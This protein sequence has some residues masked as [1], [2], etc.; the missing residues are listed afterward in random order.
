MTDKNGSSYEFGAFIL[1]TKQNLLLHGSE[2]VKLPAKAY[3]LLYFFVRNPNQ[4]I[5]KE[6]LM[7]EVWKDSFV[8]EANLAV[9]ISNLRKVLNGDVNG[10][11]AIETFPKV[12]YRF[13]AEI[14]LLEDS[15][16]IDDLIGRDRKWTG[17]YKNE[18]I[19]PLTSK[20]IGQNSFL[21][22]NRGK[23]SAL[24]IA[25][26]ITVLF[27]AGYVYFVSGDA[28]AFRNLKVVR[29]TNLGMA[30]RPAVSPDG[31]YV[32][33]A[34]DEK[35]GFSIWLK[36]IGSASET[37]IVPHADGVLNGISF[38][39]DGKSLTYGARLKGQEPGVWVIPMLGG[40]SN[41]LPLA[42]NRV[43][44]SPDGSRIVFLRNEL[45]EGK[46]HVVVA[47]ADGTDQRVVTTRQAPDYYWTA[48]E[49]SWSPDGKRVVCTAQNA[50]ESTPRLVEVDL[51]AGTESVITKQTWTTMRGV[52]W[53]PDGNG[54]LV[55]GAEETTSIRQLWYVSYPQGVATRISN[56]TINYSEISVS[57]DGHNIAT[58]ERKTPSSIWVAPVEPRGLD[59]SFPLVDTEKE[60]RISSSRADG[61]D[62]TEN[63]GGLTWTPDGK[64]VFTSEE[65]G[66]VDIWT[67]SADGSGRKQLITD[68]RWDTG[69]DVSPDG[70]T[71]AFMSRRL[72]TE[73]IWL[74][75]SDGGNQRRI[76][77]RLIERTPAFSPDGK[78]LYFTGWGTG[79]ANIWRLH[80]EGGESE[81]VVDEISTRPSI[82]D[83][84]QLLLYG[85]RPGFA[86]RSVESGSVF[87]TYT[88]PGTSPQWVPG[89]NGFS[90]LDNTRES[91]LWFQSLDSEKPVQLTNYTTDGILSYGWSRDG[92]KVAFAR[93]TLIS[94]VIVMTLPN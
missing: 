15:P 5:D 62:S 85:A 66:N 91:N 14:R 50:T 67:M 55:V 90:F 76:T 69:P 36:V 61:F 44:F 59:N 31:K 22:R 2:P 16:L 58:T 53:L 21:P 77:N 71:I 35:G 4:V 6:T 63:Y 33:Y 89:V 42:A 37:E 54:M 7:V 84:G 13:N 46:T 8:E 81:P 24:F 9:H 51:E 1:D 19:R 26:M 92:T 52:R 74:M 43:T 39:P 87:R 49:P 27:V 40:S 73:S 30:S 82:S 86:I 25:G 72:G 38:L 29:V 57:A 47:N 70:K 48:I 11:S 78:W 94:D 45:R 88:M 3:E 75:D 65:N 68:R 93:G 41:K 60:H 17:S 64:I 80:L 18:N 10:K 32:V 56:D 83:D 23:I 28:A 34:R 12:G 20:S 79:K